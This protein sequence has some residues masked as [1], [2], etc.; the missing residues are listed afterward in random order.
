MSTLQSLKKQLDEIN[1][2]IDELVEKEV[3]EVKVPEV[4]EV[5]VEPVKVP[6][7]KVS[8]VKVEPVK[9]PE[10]SEIIKSC[11]LNNS[12]CKLVKYDF[13]DDFYD[14]ECRNCESLMI[15]C[16]LLFCA[17]IFMIL[18]NAMKSLMVEL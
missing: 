18:K 9:I 14:P 13:Y 11:P 17:I 10:V 5:K 4:V 7:V 2:A 1:K 8:E 16:M 3:V 12:N 6:E 15:I